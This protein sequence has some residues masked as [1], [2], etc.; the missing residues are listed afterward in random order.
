MTNIKDIEEF[1]SHLVNQ[2]IV[3]A[4]YASLLEVLLLMTHVPQLGWLPYFIFRIFIVVNLWL[5]M[6]FRH[7]LPYLWRVVLLLGGAWLS[8]IAHLLQFGPALNAKSMMITLTF[9]AM[10][11]VSERAGWISVGLTLLILGCL[12]IF[13][14]Q[15]YLHYDFDY[16]AHIKKPQTWLGMAF[17]LTIYS[18]ITGYVAM[19]LLR[20]LQNLLAESRAQAT[21]LKA[22][23]EEIEAANRAK[24]EFLASM[25]HELNTPL[26]SILGYLDMLNNSGLSLPQRGHL[27]VI[28]QSGEHLQALVNAVLDTARLERQQVILNPAPCAL[29]SLLHHVADMVQ[30][31]AQ[32]KGLQF[33]LQLPP[34]LPEKVLVDNLRLR[35]ILLNLL[36]NSVKYTENGSIYLKVKIQSQQ[37]HEVILKFE[38]L[39]TGI[40]IPKEEQARLLLPFERGNTLGES[41]AGLGL[42]IVR[43]LLRQMD[44]ELQ[45]ESSAA[46]SCFYFQLKLSVLSRGISPV[47]TQNKISSAIPPPLALLENYW[48]ESLLGRFHCL[49]QQIEPLLNEPQYQLFATQLLNL[50]NTANKAKLQNFLRQFFPVTVELPQLKDIIPSKNRSRPQILI[51]DDDGFNIHLIA[52]YLRAFDFDIISAANGIDGVNLACHFKPHLILLDLYMTG[53][54]G[55]ETC[56]RLKTEA[57]TQTI[58]VIFFSASNKSHD[59]AKA[60]ASQGQDYILKPAREEEVIAR[61]N[62]HL[63]PEILKTSLLKR[64][65]FCE[66]HE[67]EKQEDCNETECETDSNQRIL[68]KLYQVRGLLLKDLSQE[69]S[70]EQLAQTVGLNRNKLNE[71]FRL[72]FGDT[73]FSWLR[74]QRLQ[75]AKQLLL[76]QAER[77]IQNIAETSGYTSIPH[78]SR[79]FKQRFGVSPRDYRQSLKNS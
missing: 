66:Q 48:Q 72:L 64:L 21:A 52:H 9:F 67:G 71:K 77:S 35:Q 62:A 56:Q 13:I 36:T 8:I 60:F 49:K 63:N 12:G 53:I 75:H 18:A 31:K 3:L 24:Q 69:H 20:F 70:L 32:G 6:L 22:A 40:G 10:L 1:R 23:K 33:T 46:G 57:Q 73:L 45:I 29:P 55:F 2:G 7:R 26:H 43:Q 59:I 4:A 17:T 38:V 41:G 79:A 28:R 39:D 27:A 47:F 58:P 37:T 44:S 15:D 19:Q 65:Q 68:E 42:S 54:N 78:F 50:T 11:F 30:M 76:T 25:S 61:I 5:L 16:L 34:Q 74:E 14:T 51:I